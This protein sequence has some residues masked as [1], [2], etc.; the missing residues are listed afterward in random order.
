MKKER[1]VNVV[2][3]VKKPSVANKS[4]VVTLRLDPKT[5]FGLE[6]LSRKQYRTLSSVVEWSINKTLKGTNGILDLDNIWDVYES[7]RLV[8]TALYQPNLLNYDEQ[9]IWKVIE[10]NYHIDLG[11]NNYAPDAPFKEI[12]KHYDIIKQVASGEGDVAVLEKAIKLDEQIP[13]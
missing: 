4:E 2:K 11:D 7:D 10:E 1:I 8:K 9:L 12:R 5:R 13:F 6:L 3:A